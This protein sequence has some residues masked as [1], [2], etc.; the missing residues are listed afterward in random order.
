MINDG[1]IMIRKTIVGGKHPLNDNLWALSLVRRLGEEHAFLV[2]EGM[3][4]GM[5]VA[6]KIDLKCKPGSNNTKAEIV[7][8]EISVQDLVTLGAK[9]H[10][11]T[12]SIDAAQREALESLVEAEKLRSQANL[13]NYLMLGNSKVSGSVADSAQASGSHVSLHASQSSVQEK[14][15][16]INKQLESMPEHSAGRWRKLASYMSVESVD[17]LLRHGHNCYSWSVEVVKAIRLPYQ[18]DS[19]KELVICNPTS[20]IKG[21]SRGEE[22]SMSSHCTIF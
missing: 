22:I 1:E 11:I 21:N 8:R 17:M 6:E 12:W 15:D 7:S 3:L 16:R 9:C 13:I 14:R 20:A 18:E 10:S 4:D 5:R 2:L 19:F